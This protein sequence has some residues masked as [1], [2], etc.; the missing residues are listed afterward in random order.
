MVVKIFYF[1][2]KIWNQN[3]LSK[4]PFYYFVSDIYHETLNHNILLTSRNFLNF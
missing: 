3:V 1:M 2:F 4:S